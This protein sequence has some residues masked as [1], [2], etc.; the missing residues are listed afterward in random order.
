MEWHRRERQRE[1]PEEEG[2]PGELAT[3][4]NLAQTTVLLS[5]LQCPYQ[6]DAANLF[7]KRCPWSGLPAYLF[8]EFRKN[9]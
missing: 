6:F 4:H 1:K 3:K 8:Y 2:Q 9:K 7:S 5:F